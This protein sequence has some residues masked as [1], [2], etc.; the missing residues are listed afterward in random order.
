MLDGRRLHQRVD[1][2]NGDCT[3]PV[4][5]GGEPLLA[6]DSRGEP[7]ISSWAWTK[8]G[9]QLNWMQE[10]AHGQNVYRAADDQ[11]LIVQHA[12]AVDAISAVEPIVSES[13]F[14]GRL[15]PRVSAAS[16]EPR[17]EGPVDRN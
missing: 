11:T 1:S 13:H 3:R 16:I 14:G 7:L 15:R 2:D 5:L 6:A 9:L 8:D 10:H 12:I 4:V 17:S